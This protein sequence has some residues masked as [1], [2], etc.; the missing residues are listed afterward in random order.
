[1]SIWEASHASSI[2]QCVT[3]LVNLTSQLSFQPTSTATFTQSPSYLHHILVAPWPLPSSQKQT[4]PS[5]HQFLVANLRYKFKCAEDRCQTRLLDKCV[6]LLKTAA[7]TAVA[8]CS[9]TD[10]AVCLRCKTDWVWKGKTEQ[11]DS[12]RCG[13]KGPSKGC[14][15][16]QLRRQK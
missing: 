1:M 12:S 14:L 15:N 6:Q 8:N 2:H 9:K 10:T 11:T 5:P 13:V 3:A 16:Q 7:G 4:L